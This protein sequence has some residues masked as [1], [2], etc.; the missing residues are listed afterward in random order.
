[1][2]DLFKNFGKVFIRTPVYSYRSLFNENNETKNLDDLVL[3]R[4]NDPVFIEALYWSSPQLFEAVLKFKEGC[5]NPAK[6]KKLMNTLKKYAIRAASRC[7]PYGIFAGTAIAEIGNKHVPKKNVMERKVR[8]DMG[9]LQS[10][11]AVIE[12]DPAIYPHLF[13]SVNNS[14]YS[15]PGQYRFMETVIENGKCHYQLTSLE[16]SDLLEQIIL[17][18]GNSKVSV[19]DIA[20]L[21]GRDISEEEFND[22]VTELI[23]SQFLVSELQIGLTRGDELERFISVLKRLK[24]EGVVAADKYLNLFLSVE[25]ILI[26]FE[27]IPVGKLPLEEIKELKTLLND[28]SIAA[29]DHLFHADLKQSVPDDFIFSKEQVKEI[30]H[31]IIALGKLSSNPS[32][33]ETDIENFKKLFLQKYETREILLSQALDPEF[34][35]GFPVR[36]CIGDAGFNLLIEKIEIQQATHQKHAVKDCKNWL[37]HKCEVSIQFLNESIQVTGEDLKDFEDKSSELP[38]TFSV[39]GSLLPGGQILMEAVGGTNANSLLG[40]FA[41][42]DPSMME[43]CKEVSGSEKENN[44]HV[45]FAELVFIPEGRIGNI[46]RRPVL[47]DYEIP[48]LAGASTQEK[49][50]PVQDLMVSIQHDEIILRSKKLDQR[51]IPRLSNAHNY[52]NSLVPAYKFLSAMQYQGKR[53]FGLK[54]GEFSSGNRFLPRVVYKNFI[55]HRASWY[56]Y[57]SDIDK[58]IKAK[59]PLAE[60]RSFFLK[61]NV[62]PYVCVAEADNELFIDTKNRSYL[63]LLLE[64]IKSCDSLK[65]VEWIYDTVS[66][67]PVQ[68]FILPL[69][70]KKAET[71]KQACN[72]ETTNTIA[73][74]FVPGSEWVYFKIYCGSGA[75]DKILLNVVKPAIDSLLEKHLIRKAFFIRFTDPHYHIRFRLHV[76]DKTD[77]HPFAEVLKTVYDLLNP[78]CENGFVWKVQ[79]DTYEREIERYGEDAILTTESVF[80]TTA[81]YF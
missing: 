45:I 14:L 13:Y 60:L 19:A 30:E 78:F 7:T 62:P 53:G 74:T 28:C 32:Q 54:I 77:V 48:L 2:K 46:A 42:L 22:Y 25:K 12:S 81:F 58:V 26:L 47:S 15:I 59:D 20:R 27:E 37:Q 73:R 63:Q 35:I 75:S 56:L 29:T 49:Q 11:K 66:G 3:L 52:T 38:S 17:F 80:F 36:E 44:K 31:G 40:R 16:H 76:K 41:Y 9:L 70:Q 71:F 4:I 57:K 24:G 67:M 51:V 21:A 1:M 50:I 33:N 10:I 43:V 61:W 65:L 69:S 34:G 79:L 6:E 39:M 55:F 72:G 64:E 68:Q 8:I 5:L 23:R 18:S